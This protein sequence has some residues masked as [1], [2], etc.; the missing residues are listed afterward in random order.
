MT[1]SRLAVTA[2]TVASLV[3]VLL[4]TVDLLRPSAPPRTRVATALVARGTVRVVA[5]AAGTLVP[6]NQQNAT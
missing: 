2:L 3:L 5:R 6:V 1:R 4:V